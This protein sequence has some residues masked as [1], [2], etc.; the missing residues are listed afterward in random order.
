MILNGFLVTIGIILALLS[1]VVIIIFV[2]S[3]SVAIDIIR[4]N[5]EEERMEKKVKAG[6]N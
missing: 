1:L 5:R 3:V 6:G 4:Y 2:M